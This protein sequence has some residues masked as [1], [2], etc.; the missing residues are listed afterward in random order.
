MTGLI[1]KTD[2]L[3]FDGRTVTWAMSLDAPRIERRAVKTRT[4]YVV[5]VFVSIGDITGALLAQWYSVGVGE[6]L[7]AG[8]ARLLFQ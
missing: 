8:I 7:R 2:Y 3:V 1:G 6:L 5:R 4:E